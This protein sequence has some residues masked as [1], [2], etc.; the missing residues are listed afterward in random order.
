MV[1]IGGVGKSGVGEGLRTCGGEDVTGSE[2]RG[3]NDEGD[4]VVLVAEGW[5]RGSDYCE[6]CFVGGHR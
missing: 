1:T 2:E 5:S 3:V 6:D 4:F